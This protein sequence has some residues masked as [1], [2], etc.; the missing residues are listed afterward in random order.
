MVSEGFK[1]TSDLFQD[2]QPQPINTKK[3]RMISLP[4]SLE[5]NDH[6]GFFVYNM[7][8]RQYADTLKRQFDQ[9][10]EEGEDSGTVM[11][12]PLHA[13]LIGQPHRIGPFEDVLAHV[14]SHDEA[15]VTT[16]R[17]IAEHYLDNYYDVALAD[18]A[19]YAK[20]G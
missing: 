11:C 17:E 19:S 10:L 12:I 7:S 13:Y 14:T 6:Y 5:V 9:L 20:G 1:Y 15:W 3:G 8:P 4:Y 2:D 18:I 16:G